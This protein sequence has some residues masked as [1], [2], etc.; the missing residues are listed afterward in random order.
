MASLERAHTAF[1]T[2]DRESIGGAL[3]EAY[4][5]AIA[6]YGKL[7]PRRT[8]ACA[9][10]QRVLETCIARIDQAQRTADSASVVAA[11]Q[12]FAPVQPMLALVTD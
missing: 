12:L 7:D 5:N 10:V 11:L 9:R 2:G 1:A 4:A 8:S 3:T 6:L